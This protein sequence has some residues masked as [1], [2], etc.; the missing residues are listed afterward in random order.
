FRN[1]ANLYGVGLVGVL[2]DSRILTGTLWVFL[3]CNCLIGFTKFKNRFR[4]NRGMYFVILRD[5][6]ESLIDVNPSSCC[7]SSLKKASL[8][9]SRLSVSWSCAKSINL[10]YDAVVSFFV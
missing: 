10:M 6:C 3:G 7:N 9:A 2:L 8:M 1:F 5:N 4:K